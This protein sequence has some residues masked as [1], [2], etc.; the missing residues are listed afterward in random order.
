MEDWLSSEIGLDIA[1]KRKL[2]DSV[3]S[4]TQLIQSVTSHFTHRVISAEFQLVQVCCN[5]TTSTSTAIKINC[6]ITINNEEL[7]QWADVKVVTNYPAL[8]GSESL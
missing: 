7:E 3:G 4:V 8:V 1:E 5:Y 2:P 6:L